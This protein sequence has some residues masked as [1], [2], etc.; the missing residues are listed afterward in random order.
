MNSTVLTI[1][2]IIKHMLTATII[3]ILRNAYASLSVPILLRVF[4]VPR[5]KVLCSKK[6]HPLAKENPRIVTHSRQTCLR[7]SMPYILH[8]CDCGLE[9]LSQTSKSATS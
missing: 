1:K 2:V 3:I 4:L 9:S 5:S 7:S 8:L 6:L